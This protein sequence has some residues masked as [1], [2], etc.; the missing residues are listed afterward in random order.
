MRKEEIEM[1]TRER[2]ER[3]QAAGLSFRAALAA[4][5]TLGEPT[6]LRLVALLAEAELT[7]TELTTILGQSQP[8]VSRHLKLL[9][10]ADLVERHREGAW[11]FFRIR[12]GEAAGL[13]RAALGSLAAADPTLVADRV[14]LAEVRAERARAADGYFARHAADWDRLRALHVPES[15]VEK[16][17][18][19]SVGPGPFRAV[20]DLGTGTG[21]MLALLADRAERAV[22]VDGSA[23][24]LSVARA[25]L[26][27]AGL[28]HAQVRQ[29]DIYALPV[30]RDRYDVVV[31]HQV[32]HYLDE[33]ARAIREAARTLRP[34][35]RLF[36]VDFAPHDLEFLRDEH[37]HRRLGFAREEIAD[38][39]S[40]AGLVDAVANDVGA[41]GAA[42]LTVTIWQARD[43]RILDDRRM[44]SP[45]N[46]DTGYSEVA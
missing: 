10:E 20:L 21:R 1:A 12:D 13:A 23:A 7:V 38:A 46:S 39:L 33:P 25:N 27:R 37:A 44:P 3:P 18:L 16:A 30:E 45:M 22:G 35:G 14:R 6:R 32:L 11:A 9:V 43:P 5:E 42:K 41:G 40:A 17:L 34:G 4:L 2:V 15:E 28:R 24:M 29:G 26:E 19:A 8:R 36:V 31:I